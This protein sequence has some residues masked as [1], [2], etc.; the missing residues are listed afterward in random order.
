MAP[1]DMGAALDIRR[2][3]LE[4]GHGLLK[5]EEVPLR[6]EGELRNP[7]VPSKKHVESAR[8]GRDGI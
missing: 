2:P 3:W 6:L 7:L 5:L 8:G 4:A 1:K